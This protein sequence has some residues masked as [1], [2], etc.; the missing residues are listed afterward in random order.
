M[1]TVDFYDTYWLKEVLLLHHTASIS[2]IVLRGKVRNGSVASS[3]MVI[4][5]SQSLWPGDQ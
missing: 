4:T 5:L 2:W 3:F 1:I